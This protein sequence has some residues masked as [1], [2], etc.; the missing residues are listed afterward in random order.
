MF[1]ESLSEEDD[2]ACVFLPHRNVL[3]VRHLKPGNMV[4]ASIEEPS[5]CDAD[6]RQAVVVDS[7]RCLSY[8]IS[9]TED[10]FQAKNAHNFRLEPQPGC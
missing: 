1:K 10:I 6:Q 2:A 7:G 9:E 4:D 8:M 5:N 3:Q